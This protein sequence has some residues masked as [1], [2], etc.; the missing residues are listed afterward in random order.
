[1]IIT[2]KKIISSVMVIQKF[3]IM[4]KIN[5]KP[6]FKVTML[7][8]N[9]TLANNSLELMVLSFGF[10]RLKLVGYLLWVHFFKISKMLLS[11]I[12]DTH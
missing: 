3:S 11:G 8:H 9:M 5:R 1:M 2:M 6:K 4:M 7:Q 10:Q 12:K